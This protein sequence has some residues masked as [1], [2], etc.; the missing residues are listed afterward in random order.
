L[1]SRRLVRATGIL[2]AVTILVSEILKSDS[3]SPTGP[4]QEIAT[5]FEDH[6]STILAGAYVQM[7]ALFL[8]AF[9]FAAS[10][11]ELLPQAARLGAAR[12]HRARARARRL[13][14]LHLPDWGACVRSGC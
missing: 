8:L 5:F 7:L 6:R 14:G 10:A 13:Y 4:A 11:D 12:P 9:L 3:P 2:F 1:T